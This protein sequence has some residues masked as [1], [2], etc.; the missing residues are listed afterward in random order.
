MEGRMSIA[1]IIAAFQARHA[2]IDAVK[3]APTQYPSSLNAADL[4]CVIT[5]PLR[6]KTDWESHGGDLALEVRTYRVRCF[7]LSSGLG[8]GID[9]GKQQAIAVLDAVLEGYRTEPSLTPT[10]AI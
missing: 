5:D 4:P 10:A 2:A 1:D 8:V 3:R 7:C 6:G 9:Q